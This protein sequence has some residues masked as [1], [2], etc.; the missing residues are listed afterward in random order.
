MDKLTVKK[1]I[2]INCKKNNRLKQLKSLN[3]TY[4]DF[5]DALPDLYRL[6]VSI[7]LSDLDTPILI[8][9]RE[10]HLDKPYLLLYCFDGVYYLH[11]N[12]KTEIFTDVDEV[13]DY[14]E[15]Y[16]VKKTFL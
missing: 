10:H 12:H 3:K 1:I 9:G 5:I 13:V 16:F 14:I 4:Q 6:S 15:K 11:V 2:E 8:I 7:K